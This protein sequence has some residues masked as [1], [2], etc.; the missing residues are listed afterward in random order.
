MG[1]YTLQYVVSPD[2][3]RYIISLGELQ[4]F[5]VNVLITFRSSPE[6]RAGA[7]YEFKPLIA[8]FLAI[9]IDS[10]VCI[11]VLHTRIVC[12]ED[13]EYGKPLV[14]TINEISTKLNCL[15]NGGNTFNFLVTEDIFH[16]CVLYPRI[17]AAV[18]HVERDG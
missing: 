16:T 9:P 14:V 5:S 13:G 10:L 18:V 2:E 1:E 6:I 3:G 17:E 15:I 4:E 12:N 7:W 8:H 11:L